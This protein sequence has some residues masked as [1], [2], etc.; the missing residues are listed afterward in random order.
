MVQFVAFAE[1]TNLSIV[2]EPVGS[3]LRELRA[4]LRLQTWG[5][6]VL[7]LLPTVAS[8][9]LIMQFLTMVAPAELVDAA[10]EC[11]EVARASHFMSFH[12]GPSVYCL[13]DVTEGNPWI[14][15]PFYDVLLLLVA[16]AAACLSVVSIR[17]LFTG[18]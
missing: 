5:G 14:Y 16:G 12:S 18:R 10:H 4:R 8:L 3:D 2:R 15:L 17:Q 1:V 13:H 7:L 6:A 9:F 11:Q